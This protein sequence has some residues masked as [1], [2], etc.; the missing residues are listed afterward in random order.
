MM[1]GVRIDHTYRENLL[2]TLLTEAQGARDTL[3]EINGLPLFTLTTKRDKAVYAALIAGSGELPYPPDLVKKSLET[4]SKKTVSGA[5]LKTL[6]YNKMG[7]P[8]QYARRSNGDETLTADSVTLR[9]LKLD[10]P[11]RP[12]VAQV[13]D[14]AQA[15]NK[16]QKLASFCYPKT[17]DTDG[18]FRF[19]LRLNTEASR[20]ASSQAP[21][22]LGRNSQNTPR[23]KR[24]RRLILPEP[25]HVLVEADLS[26]AE[27]RFCFVYTKDAELV[28]LARLRS[29]HF[30]QHKYVVS[31]LPKKSGTCF[32]FPLE[33]I[34]SKSDER[35]VAKSINH[36]AQRN[37]KAK[38]A[39]DTL[40]KQDERFLYTEED[41]EKML[42]AY[43]KVFSPVLTWQASIRKEVRTK[44]CLVSSWG[45]SWDVH[46]DEMNDDLFRR[47]YSW[48]MQRDC[49]GLTNQQGF[50]PLY[51]WLKKEKMASRIM[52][53]EHDSLVCSCAPDEAYDVAAFLATSLEAPREYDGIELSVPVELKI[54]RSWGDTSEFDELPDRETFE[55]VMLTYAA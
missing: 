31:I 39:V 51:R 10:H 55:K 36:A 50:I 29:S 23:D 34:P 15:H 26:Q 14:L 54:G 42:A 18:R 4:I 43:F 33:E 21:D 24:I 27:G 41:V 53:Q 20:L 32:G 25:G 30:D 37:I 7:L 19:T 35:Q 8:A 3:G 46:Y 13:V 38:T 45:H 52:L 2:R 28:R 47:A 5:Q 17:F 16:A 40:L 1:R 9:H 49:A 11:D 48:K 22:G 12:E 44:G 6:L